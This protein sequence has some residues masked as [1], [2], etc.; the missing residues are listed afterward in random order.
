L[1]ATKEEGAAIQKLYRENFGDEGIT[2]LQ[3]IA[4]KQDA[5]VAAAV[6]HRY[7]H[8]ATHGYFAAPH[9]KSALEAKAS[10]LAADG[11]AWASDQSLAGYHPGLLSGL[12]LAGANRPSA[13]DDGILTAEEVGSLDLSNAELVVLSA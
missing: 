7:L 11:S 13:E 2:T 6:R 10:G 4:A 9:L 3:G 1:P 12:A 8:L 5:L